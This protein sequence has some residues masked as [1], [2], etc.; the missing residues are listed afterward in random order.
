MKY[1][2]DVFT[3][4]TVM[5]GALGYTGCFTFLGRYLNT[6]ILNQKSLATVF[7]AKKSI[8]NWL[9]LVFLGCEKVARWPKTVF[10]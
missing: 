10:G 8:L 2:K 7:K 3:S 5:K 6:F 1:E 9:L 4:S